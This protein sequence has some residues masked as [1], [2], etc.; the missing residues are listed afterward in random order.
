MSDNPELYLELQKE[1]LSDLIKKAS[2]NTDDDFANLIYEMYKTLY[3]CVDIK[4]NVWYEFQGHRWVKIEAAYTLSNRISSEICEK[5]LNGVK[6]S[7]VKNDGDDYENDEV[8]KLLAKIKVT[9]TKLKNSTSKAGIITACKGKF[10]DPA[11]L[12]LIDSNGKL[13]GFE[14]GVYDL[15]NMQFRDGIPEDYI[16]MTTGYNYIKYKKEDKIIR[17]IEKFF[18]KLQPE[19]E[20]REYLLR[21]LAV[22]LDGT[23]SLEQFFFWP[24]SG[25]NGKSKTLQLIKETF[26]EYQKPLAVK[27]LTGP[28]PDPQAPSPAL[29]DKRGVRFVHSSEPGKGEVLNISTMKLFTGG[30]EIAAR[31]LF[32]TVFYFRPQFKMV[33]VLNDLVDIPSLDG[34]TWRRI[35]NLIFP[36]KFKSNPNPNKPYEFEKDY[37]L[38]EKIKTWKEP[39]MWYLLEVI[40]PRYQKDEEKKEGTGLKQP[41]RVISDTEDY[42]KRCDKYYEFINENCVKTDEDKSESITIL[43]ENY[44]MWFRNA[45]NMKPQNQNDFREYLLTNEY[46]ILQNKNVAGLILKENME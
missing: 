23:I 38:D 18:E 39:F 35:V 13:I 37:K 3:V 19:E 36:S 8:N 24:G 34:G 33:F 1:H 32:Q 45:Y 42:H 40:M 31:H 46:K 28:T 20:V 6:Q 15:R 30:D 10:Y 2:T 25:G 43:Y 5:I 21:F 41:K 16:T 7:L 22:C 4:N 11:F 26:G 44:K 14:N 9:Y 17:D 12:N 27:V 29:A